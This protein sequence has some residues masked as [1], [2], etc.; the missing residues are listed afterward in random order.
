M[1]VSEFSLIGGQ[2]RQVRINLDPA[3]LRAYHISAFQIMQTLQKANF[4]LPAGSFPADNRE[5]LVETG[6]FLKNSDE[7]GRVVVGGGRRPSRLPAGCGRDRRR[8][9]GAGR[10]CLHGQ[11][12]GGGAKRICRQPAGQR[13]AVTIT[14]AKKKGANASLVASEALAKVEALKG[15]SSPAMS[16]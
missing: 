16:R 5:F 8:S 4:V 7:V 13:E 9:G 6:A 2:K 15:G 12:A 1:N 3:R 10:L 14:I 11:R